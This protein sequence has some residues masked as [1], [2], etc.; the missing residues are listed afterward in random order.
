MKI[1]EVICSKNKNLFSWRH[2]RDNTVVKENSTE[3]PID[4][5]DEELSDEPVE[6]PEEPENPE[7]HQMRKQLEDFEV[8]RK[9]P[10]NPKYNLV[11]LKVLKKQYTGVSLNITG[12]LFVVADQAR[13]YFEKLLEILY[14]QEFDGKH[15]LEDYQP[16]KKLFIE[17]Y[18]VNGVAHYSRK[19][20][21][22]F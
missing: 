19:A 6:N 10:N 2:L 5:S 7:F 15:I 1:R 22:I 12:S 16:S 21:Q 13:W 8:I 17:K 18:V 20:Y 14:E 9:S 4:E 3:G 11:R